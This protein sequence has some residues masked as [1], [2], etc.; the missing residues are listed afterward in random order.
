MT[1]KS[2][3][4]NKKGMS[5][6]ET[7]V[8]IFIISLVSAMIGSLT[9]TVAKTYSIVTAESDIQTE[10]VLISRKL[11]GNVGEFRPNEAST[12]GENCISFS[13]KD[14]YSFDSGNN[15]IVDPGTDTL[16]LVIQDNDLLVGGTSI[17]NTSRFTIKELGADEGLSYKC[18]SASGCSDA[19]ITIK[20]TLVSVKYDIEYQFTTSF[21][22]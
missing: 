9:I 15:L 10:A 1:Q 12:C 11:I 4:S 5:L 17:V 21:P 19:I 16:I 22:I 14:T 7:I 8:T 13:E 6:I 3:L 18:V 2:P 20:I